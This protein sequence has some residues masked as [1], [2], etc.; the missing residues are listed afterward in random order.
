MGVV[1]FRVAL[2]A[3][4]LLGAHA[5]PVLADPDDAAS[6]ATFLEIRVPEE[7]AAEGLLLSRQGLSLQIE[8][9]GDKLLVSLIDRVTGRVVASTKIDQPPR[10]REAAVASV[11][12]VAAG[13]VTQYAGT[14]ASPPHAASDAVPRLVAPTP[15]TP[16]TLRSGITFEADLGFGLHELSSGRTGLSAAVGLELGTWIVPQR[17]VLGLRFAFVGVN[18]NNTKDA[19][20]LYSVFIGPSAQYWIDDHL[21]LGAGG[22]FVAFSANG[23]GG[24]DGFSTACARPTGTCDIDGVGADLRVGYSWGPTAHQLNISFEAIPAL[25]GTDP[26]KALF[27]DNPGYGGAALTMALTVGYQFL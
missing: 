15:S 11:T 2:I 13:L 7:L 6:L 21:W 27:G 5:R 26:G 23:V 25:Y 12:E 10:D 4:C 14:P 18:A 16:T 24:I 22:G 1:N 20:L 19:D 9:V 3:S 8:P 17:V